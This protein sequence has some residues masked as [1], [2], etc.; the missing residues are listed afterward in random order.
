[1]GAVYR[2]MD[3]VLER[4]VALKIIGPDVDDPEKRFRAEAIAI[5]RLSHPGLASVYELFE[6]DG[7]WIMV[8]ELVRGETVEQIVDRVGPLPPKR[9][10]ELC[11]RALT[12]LAHAHRA[13]VVHRDL[14]PSNLMITGLGGLKI[15]DFGIALVAGAERLTNDGYMMGTPAY[16][17][18]EQVSGRDVDGRADLYALG[19]RLLPS[20]HRPAAVQGRHAVRD[21]AGSSQGPP[22]PV[23]LIKPDMP[24]WVKYVLDLALAKSP[25]QRFQSADAF[26]DALKRALLETASG[27]IATVAADRRDCRGRRARRIGMA[28]STARTDRTPRPAS[29]TNGPDGRAIQRRAWRSG[30]GS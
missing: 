27:P 24:L 7:R 5:A 23:D 15:M 1:M 10:A 29:G 21:G 8:M 4:E 30:P 20:R 28:K 17:A 16:M 26:Y 18:P 2:A 11:M 19:D 6:H 25:D 22:I 12:A 9:A 3:T 14:K 13:G